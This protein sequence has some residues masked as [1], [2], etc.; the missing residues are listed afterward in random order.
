[1]KQIFLIIMLALSAM[2]FAQ[3][4]IERQVIGSTGGFSTLG[5]GSTISST[6]GE[7]MVQTVSAGSII[8]TQGFQQPQRTNDSIVEYLVV[9]ESCRGAKN[10]LIDI[11]DVKGCPG[12]YQVIIKAVGDTIN[13]LGHDTLSEGDYDVVIIGSNSC[14]Y[15]TVIHVGLESDEDCKLHFYTGITPNGDGRNDKWVIENIEQFPNNHVLIFNRWGQEVWSADNYDN[16]LVVWEGYNDG[17]EELADGTYFY[18]A[19][20]DGT[21]YQGWV[22]LTR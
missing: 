18:V 3:V 9:N 4:T 20:V 22:E 14:T 6:V 19:V 10:G 21:T 16:E 1:M 15:A 17:G 2:S 7:P 12:P 13:E 5:N 11:I 8:L